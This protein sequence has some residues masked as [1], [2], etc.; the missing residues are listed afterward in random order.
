MNKKITKKSESMLLKKY[1]KYNMKKRN[2][3]ILCRKIELV[4]SFA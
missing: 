1:K 4:K 3:D 2:N